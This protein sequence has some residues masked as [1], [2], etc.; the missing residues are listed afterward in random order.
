MPRPFSYA[1]GAVYSRRLRGRTPVM[2][3]GGQL[4]DVDRAAAAV[5]LAVRPAV[6]ARSRRRRRGLGDVA[7]AVSLSALAYLIYFRIIARAGA[8]NA[9][10]VTFLIPVSAILSGF[11]LLD[12]RLGARQLAG[13]AGDLDRPRRHRRPS[14]A[15][16]RAKASAAR[17]REQSAGS[18]A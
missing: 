12:E 9:L 8:T 4:D 5:R 6:D 18:P 3:A 7:L 2:V 17:I 15:I 10:L 11:V 1:F 14:G 13:M 16:H